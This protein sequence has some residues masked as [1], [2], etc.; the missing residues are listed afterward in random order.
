MVDEKI[1][2]IFFRAIRELLINAAKHA[3]ARTVRV[4]LD[5]DGEL[6]CVAVEDDGV[7]M[8][9]DS[10]TGCG[11]GLFSIRE[12]LGHVGGSMCVDSAPGRGTKIQL[13]A[14]SACTAKAG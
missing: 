2:V 11:S 7:G 12:R 8:K 6:V 10:G 4:R 13:R 5:S 3:E 9:R 1:R 14:P